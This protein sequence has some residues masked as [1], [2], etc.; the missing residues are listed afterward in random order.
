MAD[1]TFALVPLSLL[2]EPAEPARTR[3]DTDELAELERSVRELGLEQ[4]LVVFR[5]PDG[6]CEVIAGHRRLIVCRAIPL[7]PVPCMVRPD[8]LA[9]HA[10]RV[11]EN[12]HREAWSA[13]DEALYYN[14]LFRELGED[15]DRVAE[16]VHRTR[17]HVENRLLLLQGYDEVFTALAEKRITLGVAQELNR[18]ERPEDAETY[19]HAAV[20]G[21]CTTQQMMVWRV[22]A[23]TLAAYA[24]NPPTA[25]AGTPQEVQSPK[26]RMPDPYMV[27]ARPWELSSSREL[28]PCA[29]CGHID[30]SWLMFFTPLCVPCRKYFDGVETAAP[31]D[32][33]AP[34]GGQA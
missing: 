29:R 31:A 9:L 13:T 19:L 1:S 23:N 12:V 10:L 22:Q 17:Q 20:T 24:A 30:E 16:T 7:D 18:M 33:P 32:A 34:T 25:G 14:R 27:T 11:H 26:L 3:M 2:D 15:V 28:R 21:G 8:G 5:K 4:P 6:R